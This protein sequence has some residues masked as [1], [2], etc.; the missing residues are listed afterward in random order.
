MASIVDS[1]LAARPVD[2]PVVARFELGDIQIERV[3]NDGA[4]LRDV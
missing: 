2:F 4:A 1:Y 3:A